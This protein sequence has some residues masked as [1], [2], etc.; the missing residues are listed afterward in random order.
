MVSQDDIN[1]H[2][3]ISLSTIDKLIPKDK[4]SF[5]LIYY[6]VNNIIKPIQI[7]ESKKELSRQAQQLQDLKKQKEELKKKE[8]STEIRTKI[9]EVNFKLNIH[10]RNKEKENRVQRIREII[11]NGEN[12]NA[13]FFNLFRNHLNRDHDI[14][15]VNLS[16]NSQINDSKEIDKYFIKQFKEM[17]GAN[18]SNTN[19]P[20]KDPK[21][22]LTEY[23]PSPNI[24]TPNQDDTLGISKEE[25]EQS[26]K[27]TQKQ[28]QYWPRWNII[29]SY[30]IPIL[31]N[32][33][34]LDRSS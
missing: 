27:K 18:T 10:Y 4:C 15:M 5:N 6:L 9:R 32:S 22:F 2:E 29:K 16:D 8:H 31:N 20:L 26:V 21:P 30:E 25:I 12:L 34:H 13:N 17:L 33:K 11:E 23:C 7:E 19:M 28:V 3:E 14:R 1:P 24:L